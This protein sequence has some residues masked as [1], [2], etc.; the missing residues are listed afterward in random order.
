MGGASMQFRLPKP[1]NGWRVFVGEIAIIVIGVLIALGAQSLLEEW[2]WREEV[3]ITNGA[4]RD[5]LGEAS[6]VAYERL[7]IQPCLQGRIRDLSQKLARG[8]GAWQASPMAMTNK[9]FFNIMPVAYRGPSR[10]VPTD[11]WKNAM[12]NG[13]LNHI[14]S[15]RVRELSSLYD[16]VASFGE[17]YSEEARASARLTPLAFNRLLDSGSRTDLL[18]SLAEVDRINGLMG[19]QASQ[20]IERVRALKFNFPKAEVEK[21]RL[22]IVQTQRA[23]RGACVLNLPFNP[24]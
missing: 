13:T 11:S 9:Q 23:V 2:R 3:K 17:L 1:L 18:G 19:L 21:G 12:A 4:F 5:E 8:E 14:P 6:E 16:Q 24:G 10:S 15:E 22:E 20:I 7:I